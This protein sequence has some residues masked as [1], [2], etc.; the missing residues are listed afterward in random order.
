MSE[1]QEHPDELQNIWLQNDAVSKM[2]DNSTMM[3]LL[4]EK[5]RSFHDFVHG[6][7]YTGYI[8]VGIYTP[9]TAIAA[10]MAQSN[11]QMKIGFILLTVMFIA[12]AIVTWIT[13]RKTQILCGIDLSIRD[14]HRELQQLFERRIRF[15]KGGKYWFAIPYSFGIFLVFTPVTGLFCKKPWD[16]LLVIGIVVLFWL[17]ILYERD[18][19]MVGRLQRRKSEVDA[20]LKRMDQA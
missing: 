14:Y 16:I 5:H 4:R 8:V 12:A 18:Y 13:N 3:K 20:L 9:I 6:D 19:R 10:W 11:L 7:D 2:A 17:S 15:V 1:S